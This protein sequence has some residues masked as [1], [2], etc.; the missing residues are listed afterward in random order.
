MNQ[1]KPIIKSIHDDTLTKF[2]ELELMRGTHDAVI[3]RYHTWNIL[4][5]LNQKERFLCQKINFMLNFVTSVYLLRKFLESITNIELR[6]CLTNVQIVQM[7][8]EWSKCLIVH[9]ALYIYCECVIGSIL[10][11]FHCHMPVRMTHNYGLFSF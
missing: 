3:F 4:S 9:F 10:N 2:H 1:N 8:F 5:T 6:T 7:Y 11:S